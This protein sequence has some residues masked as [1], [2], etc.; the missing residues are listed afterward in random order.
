MKLKCLVAFLFAAILMIGCVPAVK[1]NPCHAPPGI[2]QLLCYDMPVSFDQTIPIYIDAPAITMPGYDSNYI[3][4]LSVAMFP[5][6]LA[7]VPLLH[8]NSVGAIHRTPGVLRQE[9]SNL[10]NYMDTCYG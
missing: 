1:G 9:V 5:E 3:V 2:S 6:Y 10:P 8:N 7:I 4:D